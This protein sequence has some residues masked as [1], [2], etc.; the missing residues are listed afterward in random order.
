MNIADIIDRYRPE[1]EKNFQLLPSHHKALNAMQRCRRTGTREVL[2]HCDSCGK[3]EEYLLSCGHRSCPHCQNHETTKWLERQKNKLLPVEY[4]MATFTVP[5][6]LRML[7]Y[8]NQ[9]EF[10]ES[11]LTAATSTII[12]FGKTNKKLNGQMGMTAVLHTHNRRL[13]VHPHVHI[14]VPNGALNTKKKRWCKKNGKYLFRVKSLS[15]V[16]R[17]KLLQQLTKS[18]L[19]PRDYPQKWVVNCKHVGKG[20]PALE[21]LSRY[22][23]KGVIS[24]N[25][26]IDDSNG[27]V[28]FSYID[29]ETGETKCRTEKGARFLFLVIQHIL[30]KGFRR[31]RDYG[32]LHGNS[33]KKLKLLQLILH[34]K[35][36]VIKKKTRATYKCPC[37]QRPMRIVGI[38]NRWQR[39]IEAKI[40]GA[41]KQKPTCPSTG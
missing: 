13:D 6:E 35:M 2:V 20:L 10:Y 16:F 24:E 11:L 14:I 32:F 31:V 36:P 37:C 27:M 7:A 21:Y 39:D 4:F 22:L 15:K 23:Y 9:K 19:K 26:I 25:S 40:S 41:T 17:A 33:K 3:D 12:S 18:G 5:F 38:F 28:T 8:R 1:L 30:P 29:S 34:V